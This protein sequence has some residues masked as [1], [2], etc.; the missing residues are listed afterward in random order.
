M[1]GTGC[2]GERRRD[3]Q[4]GTGRT[5]EED[6]NILGRTCCCVGSVALWGDPRALSRSRVSPVAAQANWTARRHGAALTA[7]RRPNGS[8]A[9]AP[10]SR[11]SSPSELR[12]DDEGGRKKERGVGSVRTTA[13]SSLYMDGTH[14]QRGWMKPSRRGKT[15]ET[16]PAQLP[17]CLL[18]LPLDQWVGSPPYGETIREYS[19]SRCAQA[20]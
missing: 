18:L 3:R 9:D 2:H 1:D 13:A 17:P 14:L 19:Y 12:W 8:A 15:R 6:Q 10:R 20:Q 7:A 11:S 5:Q 4:P 16:R